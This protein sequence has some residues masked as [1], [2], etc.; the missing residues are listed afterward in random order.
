MENQIL[1]TGHSF[2]WVQI[3]SFNL[4][5]K[6][7]KYEKTPKNGKTYFYMSRFVMDAFYASTSFPA[8]NWN[9]TD[10][11]SPAHIYC[12]NMW[13]DNFIPHIYELCDL[14]LRSM[15]YNIFKADAPTF[16]KSA[17]ELIS[18]FGD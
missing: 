6:N 17:R 13:D 11:S 12:T 7:E 4:W 3:P 9:W 15:Y 10:Q 1:L 5:D 16:S 8:L 2:N 18:M 14:F